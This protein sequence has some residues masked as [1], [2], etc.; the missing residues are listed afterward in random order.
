LL[1]TITAK[2]ID[3]PDDV[4]THAEEKTAKLPRYYSSINQVE[5]I[6]DGNKGSNV[7]VEIIA[8]AE[9]NKIFVATQAGDNLNTC[10]DLAVH[11]LEG[12]I[13]RT[14]GKERD[15]KHKEIA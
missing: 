8:R 9:H 10:I 5:V 1:F 3:V 6:I 14:K 11:K 12:R 13:R 4:K 15:N 2:H 7:T